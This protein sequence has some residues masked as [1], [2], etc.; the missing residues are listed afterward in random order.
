MSDIKNKFVLVDNEIIGARVIFHRNIHPNPKGGGWWYYH[1]EQ[2]KLVLY[3][4]SFDFG[5]ITKEQ[6]L[7]AELGGSFLNM[8]DV[9][10]IFDER[11]E[12]DVLKILMEHLGYDEGMK[13]ATEC[14][15]I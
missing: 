15:F 8:E 1:R 12:I 14:D 10:V 4:S 2:N 5:S 6:A 7:N 9:E 13:C 11:N 3:G